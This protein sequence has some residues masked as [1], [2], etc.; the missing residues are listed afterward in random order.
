MRKERNL[1]TQSGKIMDVL[2]KIGGVISKIVYVCSIVGQI[3]C[4]V[5]IC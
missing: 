1:L 4:I 2:V 5:V 3:G